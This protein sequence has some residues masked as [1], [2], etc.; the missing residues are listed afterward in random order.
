M[1]KPDISRD[2]YQD[3]EVKPGAD[4]NEIKKQFK[5]LALKY[6]PDRNPGHESE[7]ISK[8]QA[9]NVAHEVLSDPT[10][11]AKYD[12]D[13]QKAGYR[14]YA[15]M[16]PRTG[17]P[18]RN[19]YTP[20]YYPAPPPPPPPPPP[21]QARTP[22]NTTTTSTGAKRFSKYAD[23]FQ[24]GKQAGGAQETP[25]SR[26]ERYEAWGK[27]KPGSG[28]FV[29]PGYRTPP[30]PTAGGGTNPSY[31]TPKRVNTPNQTGHDPGRNSYSDHRAGFSR[32]RDE[33]NLPF[34]RRHEEMFGPAPRLRRKGFAPDAPG[35]DEPPARDS[36]A[37]FVHR[38]NT[39][40]QASRTQ[41]VPDAPP[42][43]SPTERKPDPTSFFKPSAEESYGEHERVST[44]YATGGGERTYFSSATLGRSVSTR[45]G[46]QLQRASSHV[47]PMENLERSPPSHRRHRSVSASRRRRQSVSDESEKVAN[48][49]LDSPAKPD[50]SPINKTS[51]PVRE[52]SSVNKTSNDTHAKAEQGKS[53]FAPRVESDSSGNEHDHRQQRS[54][55]ARVR[56]VAPGGRRKSRATV[57]PTEPSHDRENHASSYSMPQNRQVQDPNPL[58]TFTRK[59]TSSL[60][61]RNIQDQ[62]PASASGVKE[63]T[64][65]KYFYSFHNHSK[66]SRFVENLSAGPN[67]HIPDVLNELN[68]S[69]LDRENGDADRKI[70]T[71]FSFQTQDD[72][73]ARTPTVGADFRSKS[74]ENINNRFSPGEWNGKFE[75]NIFSGPP[76]PNRKDR[77][78][79]SPR[80]AQVP[81]GRSP[82]RPPAPPR[83]PMPPTQPGSFMGTAAPTSSP[84]DP[85][86]ALAMKFLQEDWVGAIKQNDFHQPPPLGS[87]RSN[88]RMKSGKPTGAPSRVSKATS[89]G[90]TFGSDEETSTY[91]RSGSKS[92][93]SSSSRS[94]GFGSAMEIDQSVPAQEKE[95]SHDMPPRP[96]YVPNLEEERVPPTNVGARHSRRPSATMPPPPPKLTSQQS[97]V[98]P[99]PSRQT[100]PRAATSL[101]HSTR[102]AQ[103]IA[104]LTDLKNVEPF[105]FQSNGL[106]GMDSIS[107]SLPFESRA[108]STTSLPPRNLT[109]PDP[110]RAPTAPP[111]SRNIETWKEYSTSM[112]AYVRGWRQ[113]QRQM[114]VHF[115]AREAQTDGL[116]LGWLQSAGEPSKGGFATYMRGLEEDD[117]VRMHWTVACDKHHEA[118]LAFKQ[119]RDAFLCR[120]G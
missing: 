19:P 63:R 1:V 117:R 49:P 2:Y 72:M 29:N 109:L 26:T 80:R 64:P 41:N 55:G 67:F 78:Q 107:S 40:P 115:N 50:F 35:G 75:S 110:P 88:P 10:L 81:Q 118:M 111:T 61:D 47:H 7:F 28:P 54:S 71:S 87:K 58:D 20:A 99:A 52:R 66:A 82:N 102:T 23:A 31:A 36:S 76:A 16:P 15:S 97:A 70:N 12:A 6:H 101:G 100:P 86:P 4:T 79:R 43:P 119:C 27:M 68:L 106:S 85:P 95:R 91:D 74:T 94:S 9:I 22:Y 38:S 103:P 113:F 93:E 8:F 25:S 60:N 96:V 24:K 33:E 44:P 69:Q 62:R 65:P 39:R 105:T 59:M 108:S 32:S 34:G 92:A 83:A 11:R 114:L 42:R 116:T 48:S 84:K 13:R 104:D 73:F 57:E 5:K 112:E 90:G 46:I 37:Y 18:P 77:R 3:L 45:E 98:P 89:L 53:R 51:R 14:G 120:P 21:A 17:V 30:K 56:G